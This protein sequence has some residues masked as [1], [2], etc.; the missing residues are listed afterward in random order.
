MA[1]KAVETLSSIPMYRRLGEVDREHLAALSTVRSYARGDLIF[2]E[3]DA[4]DVHF[5]IA[6]GR[7]KV[8]KTPVSGKDIILELFGP[9]DPLGTVAVY[10]SR[11]YP[12][13]AVALAYA[14]RENLSEGPVQLHV[15]GG[16]L[17]VNF[18][19]TG[20]GYSE[21]V[22]EGP[23]TFVFEGVTDI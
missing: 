10:D 22:L 15:D 17:A 20:H 7:V 1:S 4:A 13:T 11:H 21:I 6:S 3:G 19:R 14:E 23:A 18:R 12:A 9:G 8:F 2:S 5:V 16:D